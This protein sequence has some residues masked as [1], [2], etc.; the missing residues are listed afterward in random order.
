MK[1]YRL[2]KY[3]PSLPTEWNQEWFPLDKK[4]FPII[5]VERE[6]GYYLHPSLK[7][8]TRETVGFTKYEVENSSDYWEEVVPKESIIK[9]TDGLELIAGD[10]YYVPQVEGKH[11]R[12]TGSTVMF[13]VQPDMPEDETKRFANKENA[14]A[15]IENNIELFSTKDIHELL[16]K[17]SRMMVDSSVYLELSKMVKERLQK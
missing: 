3:Y 6:D 9:T 12:L 1:E 17:Y 8:W 14:Q 4:G 5:V 15:Y 13:Y 7:G 10:R 16:K 11:R 2:L